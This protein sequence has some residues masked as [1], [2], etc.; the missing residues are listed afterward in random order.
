MFWAINLV[1]KHAV[2]VGSALNSNTNIEVN[3]REQL[4]DYSLLLSGY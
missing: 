2:D 3:T 1:I 4:W